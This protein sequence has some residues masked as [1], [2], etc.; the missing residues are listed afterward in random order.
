[1]RIAGEFYKE[2][3]FHWAID[4]GRSLKPQR[5]MA[6]FLAYLKYTE[7]DNGFTTEHKTKINRSGITKSKCYLLIF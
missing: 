4:K 1:M 6:H 7:D 3:C 2:I 5:L